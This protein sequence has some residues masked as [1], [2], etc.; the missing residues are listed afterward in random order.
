MVHVATDRYFSLFLKG[1]KIFLNLRLS[2]IVPLTRNCFRVNSCLAT[3]KNHSQM[4]TFDSMFIFFVYY[5]RIQHRI[6]SYSLKNI[7]PLRLR[8]LR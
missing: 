1:L 8:S 3:Q 7:A 6:Q 5:K 2:L 4:F